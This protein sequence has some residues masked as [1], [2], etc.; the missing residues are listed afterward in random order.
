MYVHVYVPETFNTVLLVL[1]V[2]T[3]LHVMVEARSAIIRNSDTSVGTPL[4]F[5]LLVIV[6]VAFPLITLVIVV[7][8]GSSVVNRRA[9]PSPMYSVLLQASIKSGTSVE[10]LI[11]QLKMT[12]SPRQA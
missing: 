4:I 8:G 10:P 12:S 5:V 7:P 1:L 6:A 3:L 2:V 9:I 11:V